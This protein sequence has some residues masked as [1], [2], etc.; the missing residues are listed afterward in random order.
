MLRP[1]QRGRARPVVL[2]HEALQARAP[3]PPA[4]RSP[5]RARGRRRPPRRRPRRSRWRPARGRGRRAGRAS[6]RAARRPAAPSATST[7]P[8]RQ[9]RP[10]ESATTTAGRHAAR[11]G[12]ARRAARAPSRRGPRGAGSARPGR[13]CWTGR[14]RRWRT[15]SRGGSRTPARRAR[16]AG[17]AAD[18]SRI[19]CT[20]RGSLSARGVR[21]ASSRARS[22]G[23]ISSEPAGAP[24]GL[25]H[26]LVS[27][28]QHVAGVAG[29]RGAAAAIS[30]WQGVTGADL[31]HA[32]QGAQRDLAGR[33]QAPTRAPRRHGGAHLRAVDLAQRA[34]GHRR[35]AAARDE[36]LAQLGEVLGRVHVECQRSHRVHAVRDARGLRRGGVA[37][38]AAGAEGRLDRRRAA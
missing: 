4:R 19:A 5:W 37:F 23:S 36:R 14:R 2:G 35:L 26:H 32:L 1:A 3:A 12:D 20:R 28:H 8:S 25:G 33:A 9:A 13:R 22:P 38:Q 21:A 6:R 30:S 16:R 11:G 7:W 34:A 27:H 18:S 29:P 24:L 31:G 15:R 17:S 10:K